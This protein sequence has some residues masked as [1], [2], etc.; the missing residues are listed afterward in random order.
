MIFARKKIS[1][2]PNFYYICP[3]N[4]QHFRILH[5][6]S[7]KIPEFYII[8]RKIFFSNIRRARA[9]LLPSPTPMVRSWDHRLM[10]RQLEP[11]F[12]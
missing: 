3:K 5:D 9:P 2:Y 4:L 11:V 1:K 10:G 7:P 8:A 12:V 6:F